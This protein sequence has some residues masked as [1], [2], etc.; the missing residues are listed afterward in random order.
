MDENKRLR[1]RIA[2]LKQQ[3][4]KETNVAKHM[5]LVQA[6]KDIR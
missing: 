2:T 1:E 4:N 3:H 5:Q 6:E